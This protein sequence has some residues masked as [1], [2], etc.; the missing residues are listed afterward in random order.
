MSLKRVLLATV[1]AVAIS[2]AAEAQVSGDPGQRG[3]PAPQAVPPSAALGGA[4]YNGV[5]EPERA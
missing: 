3:L 2:G 1:F 4:D 5:G